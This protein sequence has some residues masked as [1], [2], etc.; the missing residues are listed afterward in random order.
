MNGKVELS[1]LDGLEYGLTVGIEQLQLEQDT[2]KSL[3]DIY[4]GLTLLDLNRAGTGLMEIVTKPDLR[5]SK[6]AGVVVKKLQTLLR[7]VDSS[8]GNMDEGSMRCDVNVSVHEIGKP[9]GARCELKNLNSIKSVM[10]AI[11]AEIERQIASYESD[12]VVAQET[13]GFDAS[14]GKTYRIRSKESAPDYR[15][16][17]EPDLPRLVISQE[18]IQEMKNALPELP[19][20][21][22]YRI[23]KLYGLGMIE[24]RTLMGED[25]MVEYFE[26]LV[27]TG[28]QVK[29]VIS[30]TIHE[31]LGRL[32]S[33]NINFSSEIVTASQLGS[34]VDYVDQGLISAKVGKNVL[35]L[36]V[37]GDPRSAS[38]IVEEKGWKQMDNQDE[39]GQ[40]CEAIM[41]QYPDKVKVVQKGNVGVLGFFVGQIMKESQGRA[42]PVAVSEILRSKMGLQNGK[43]ADANSFV[44]P[45]TN[46]TGKGDKKKQSK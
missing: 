33:R 5:S 41:A 24:T 14:T 32:H 17:P 4:P 13:R 38:E 40:M 3:H 37:E 28:R 8:D 18:K 34:L 29:S 39:L 7:A 11:D 46:R 23:M 44:T 30:W 43:A 35:N 45:T 6:E 26:D 19:D 15:Y 1:P 25:G 10:D 42:N 21:R 16:M 22:R 31:L 20:A 36:M 27:S 9:Y 12:I 2:G